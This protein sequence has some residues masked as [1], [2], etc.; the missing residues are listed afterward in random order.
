MIVL[1]IDTAGSDCSAAIYDADKQQLVAARQETI[2]KGHAERLTGMIQEVLDEAGMEPDRISIIGVTIGPGSFTGIRVGV[3]AARGLGLALSVP[4]AGITTLEALA[5][6]AQSNDQKRVMSVIDA[7][8]GEVYL[9]AFNAKGEAE[10][11]P[12]ALKVEDAAILTKN[13]NARLTGSGAHLLNADLASG[14]DHFDIA[15]IA[16]IAASRPNASGKPAP[17]YLRGPDAKPQAGFAIARQA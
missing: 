7:K 12:Q 13:S 15:A 9:Q 11:E 17:L 6:H 2:G 4:V 8:R 3:A 16:R 10:S 14:D 5:A 1:A